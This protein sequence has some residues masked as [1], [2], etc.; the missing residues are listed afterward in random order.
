[1]EGVVFE[2]IINLYSIESVPSL[3]KEKGDNDIKIFNSTEAVDE[4]DLYEYLL[5]FLE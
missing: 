1:M 3:I 5:G 2:K 4:I